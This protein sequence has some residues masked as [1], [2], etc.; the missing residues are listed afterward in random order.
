MGDNGNS[1]DQIHLSIVWY[2]DTSMALVFLI[3]N[4]EPHTLHMILSAPGKTKP[5]FISYILQP[6]NIGTMMS[7]YICINIYV[8][9]MF[10][11][12]KLHA[13]SNTTKQIKV[14][15]Q[16]FYTF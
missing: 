15:D 10:I 12:K 9:S 1:S 11:K 14:S 3:D 13:K 6:S 5:A 16:L 4:A 8:M 2:S 7:Q